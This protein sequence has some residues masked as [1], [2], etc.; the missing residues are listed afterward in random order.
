[1]TRQQPPDEARFL[2]E[3]ER[4]L[5]EHA[6]SFENP[7]MP[8]TGF[9]DR[10]IAEHA[11]VVARARAWE[12]SKAAAGWAGIGVPAE[13]GGRGRSAFEAARF[14]EF[15][16]RYRLD[17]ETFAVA[18]MMVLP[19]LLACGTERQKREHIPRLLDGRDVWCQLFS[20]PGAGSDLAGLT[21]QAHRRGSSW[22][23]A[24]QKVWTSGAN[25]ADQGYL[26][27][28]TA[29]GGAKHQGLTAFVLDMSDPGIEVRPI[30]QATGGYG[31]CEVFLDGVDVGDEAVVG[32]VGDG[33]RV[34]ITTLM[35]ER[36]AMSAANIPWP[37]LVSL[38]TDGC[39]PHPRFRE[40][41][42]RLR[43]A[44]VAVARIHAEEVDKLRSRDTVPGPEG[45]ILKLMISR[46]QTEVAR[47]ALDVLA[48]RG[49]QDT[50]WL[51]SY[52]GS[53]GTR[54]GGGTEEILKNVIADRVLGLPREPR[55]D[56]AAVSGRGD[57][58]RHEH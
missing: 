34:A 18:K 33:W 37:Q 25:V 43:A 52:L 9:P 12:T 14:A 15:E 54:I 20:E 24:G 41:A 4:W 56:L 3:A 40:S 28:R 35:N 49:E 17:F 2:A 30:R 42:A 53:F 57:G 8:L 5:A 48:A 38:L 26:L 44:V 55:L 13:W 21:T 46:L 32:E 39:E 31:F 19:T 58:T 47:L 16:S 11:R 51:D 50:R 10:S 36:L 23:I 6:P 22:R 29:G 7:S 1:V 27:A 45:S